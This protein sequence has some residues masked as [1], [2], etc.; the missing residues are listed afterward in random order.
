MPDALS[1]VNVVQKSL[2][3]VSAEMPMRT[4]VFTSQKGGSGKTTL[5]GQLAVQGNRR[6]GDLS[7]GGD[8]R[9]GI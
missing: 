2:T 7:G 1:L 3:P 6:R 4:L 9:M 5:C 8:L